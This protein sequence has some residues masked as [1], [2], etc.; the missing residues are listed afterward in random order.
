MDQ[1]PRFNKNIA[2]AEVNLLVSFFLSQQTKTTENNICLIV[3]HEKAR[4][5][6]LSKA[7]QHL[8]ETVVLFFMLKATRIL[9]VIDASRT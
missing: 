7:C 8:G 1:M 5:I 4:Y 3:S 6:Y 2:K 9:E